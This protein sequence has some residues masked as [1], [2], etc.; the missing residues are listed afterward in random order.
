MQARAAYCER[1]GDGAKNIIGKCYEAELN[2][3]MNVV[4]NFVVAAVLEEEMVD[5]VTVKKAKTDY[6]CS[7]HSVFSTVRNNATDSFVVRVDERNRKDD[8]AILVLADDTGAFK[9]GP[10]VKTEK[11]ATFFTKLNTIAMPQFRGNSK[12]KLDV[13]QREKCW[14]NDLE[15]S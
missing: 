12:Q 5:V 8:G 6:N 1:A 4:M 7:S 10:V 13:E 14:L 3:V 11:Y 15:R 2:S 9:D